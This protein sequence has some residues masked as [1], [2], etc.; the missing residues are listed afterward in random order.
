MLLPQIQ[1]FDGERVEVV[2]RFVGHGKVVSDQ[3]NKEI[4][5]QTMISD[6]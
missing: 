4:G 2:G 5:D 3:R 1:G 6:H